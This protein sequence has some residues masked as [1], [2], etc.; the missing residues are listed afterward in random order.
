M[1]SY[2]PK[3]QIPTGVPLLQSNVTTRT[4][5]MSLRKKETE[6]LTTSEEIDG[7]KGVYRIPV[8]TAIDIL[9]KR[10]LPQTAAIPAAA[11]AVSGGGRG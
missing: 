11:P 4:D 6:R 3:T 7:G 10:G 5:I 9:S 1:A 8:K 2:E